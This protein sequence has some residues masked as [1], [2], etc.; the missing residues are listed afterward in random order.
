MNKSFKYIA[1]CSLGAMMA[2]TALTAC[3]DL[4]TLPEDQYITAGQKEESISANP[5]LAKAGVVGISSTY[6][7]Y[8]TV[9]SGHLD[10]GWPGVMMLIECMGTDCVCPD[11]GYNW[12]ASS[13]DYNFG[14]VNNYLNN[15]SWTYAY[16]IINSANTVIG[17]IPE[18][19]DNAELQ[20]YAA[21]AYANRAYM[22]FNLAQLYQMTYKGH[23][24]LPCVPILT[25]KNSTEAAANGCPRGKVS[26]VY[27]QILSDLDAA[28]KYLS[29]SGLSIDRLADTGSK[30]FVS[31][32]TAY[33]L[34]ARVNLVMN[35]WAAAASDAKDAIVNSGCTPYSIAEASHPAF[36]NA[37]DHNL[38]WCVYIQENDRVV[39]SGIVNWASHMG[40]LNYG[41]ASVGGWRMINE[42]LFNSIPD[43]D[44]RKGWW[45]DADGVSPNLNANEAAV[46]AGYGAPAYTQMKFGPYQNVLQTTT[47]A[48]SVILMR[49]EEMYLI[50]AEATA[51]ANGD[52][53]SILENFVKTYR[54]PSYTCPASSGDAF[55]D[56]VWR[57]RRIE[58]WGEA[59]SYFDL[60]R[61]NKPLDRR[62][63]GW[64]TQWVYNVPAPLKPILIPNTEVQSNPALGANNDTWS[65]PNSVADF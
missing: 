45:L 48:T 57:Q 9:Y 7:Q 61:L 64:E 21:Q 13:G 20:L 41:Y 40:S 3:N 6:N 60:L 16:Q 54:D 15:M 37:E 51:R 24:D 27:A 25:D 29:E 2:S 34:R 44:C 39:T 11:V 38:M 30:R 18:D 58:L 52:G 63:G 53:K 42:A 4:D 23:E 12:F 46:A 28:I 19:T 17:N 1:L 49:V 56:E 26:E 10:F 31:L 14:T 8:Q 33:G 62:G 32:G 50:Q 59:I 36:N 35:N 43:T 47:N 55:Y 5:E 65:K 22:Y